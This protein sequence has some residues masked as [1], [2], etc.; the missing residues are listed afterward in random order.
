MTIRE[1]MKD[2]S[3]M[4]TILEKVSEEMK[5]ITFIESKSDDEDPQLEDDESE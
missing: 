3:V 2:D 4:N 1:C 5:F